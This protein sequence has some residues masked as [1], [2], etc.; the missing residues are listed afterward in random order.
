MQFDGAHLHTGSLMSNETMKK[1]RPLIDGDGMVYRVGFA[2]KEG[3]P[4]EYALHSMKT[5]LANI[6]D[7]FDPTQKPSLYISGKD[8]FREKVAFTLPY[9]ENRKDAPKPIYYNE[10]R[11]YMVEKHSAIVVNGREADDAL[12]EEQSIGQQHTTCI[13][14]QDKDMKTIAGYN[15]NWVTEKFCDVTQENADLFLLWQ[16]IQGDRTDNIPGLKGYGKAKAT[17]II[18]SYSKDI[19]RIKG[20]VRVLY[21]KEFGDKWLDVINEQTTLLFIQREPGKTFRDYIGEW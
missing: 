12:G 8:N 7:K 14:S 15:Y 5:T 21:K 10:L 19:H 18:K 13:V 3:E 11:E 2:S 6:T 20:R 17:D 4:I 1:L 16:V 9:K